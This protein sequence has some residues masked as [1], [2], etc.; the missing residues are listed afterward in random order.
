MSVLGTAIDTGGECIQDHPLG[1]GLGQGND[2]ILHSTSASKLSMPASRRFFRTRR[3]RDLSK[4]CSLH[5]K[6][7]SW[8]SRSRRCSSS[9]L[10][11]A[12]GLSSATAVAAWARY[13]ASR[14]PRRSSRTAAVAGEQALGDE[15]QQHGV[16]ALEGR[17]DI[18]VGLERGEAVDGEVALPTTGLTAGLD[19]VRRVPGGERL[20]SSRQGLRPRGRL[21]GR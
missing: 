17:E 5:T 16:V 18:A 19:R 4:C 2:V 21:L 13:F 1:M 20:E 10:W 11:V 12:T 14:T 7:A 8:K 9:V 3:A 15:L 6:A